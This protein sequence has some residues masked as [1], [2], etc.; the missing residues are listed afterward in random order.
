MH[1][2]NRRAARGRA[3]RERGVRRVP[4]RGLRRTVRRRAA[5]SER[6]AGWRRSRSPRARAR[7]LKGQ[8]QGCRNGGVA[9][10]RTARSAVSAAGACFSWPGQEPAAERRHG[11]ALSASGG[12]CRTELLC[13]SGARGNA[14][15]WRPSD[16]PVSPP[17]VVIE[18]RARPA[19]RARVH[20]STLQVAQ[21]AR[22][23][24]GHRPVFGVL[25]PRRRPRGARCRGRATTDCL[26][27][28]AAVE[29]RR[30]ATPAVV[31][32]WLRD[33]QSPDVPARP[34]HLSRRV[35]TCVAPELGDN[36]SRARGRRT[37]SRR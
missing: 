25:E 24:S 5:G 19:T 20:A 11:R 8:P 35:P 22:A 14:Q 29:M 10:M 6:R 34:A 1:V 18:A 27:R 13:P 2:C 9:S 31:R 23:S 16:D 15:H 26:A 28:A 4:K 7:W 37:R 33:A 21:P 32:S 3:A 36:S 12:G 30:C 17:G